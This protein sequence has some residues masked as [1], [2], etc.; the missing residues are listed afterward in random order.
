M[1]GTLGSADRAE[2]QCTPSSALHSYGVSFLRT[3]PVLLDTVSAEFTFPLPMNTLSLEARRT[4][5]LYFFL[6]FVT[7][8]QF[9]GMQGLTYTNE[10]FIY[11]FGSNSWSN[12][13]PTTKVGWLSVYS[14]CVL[15]HFFLSFFFFALTNSFPSLYSFFCWFVASFSKR[16]SL[17]SRWKFHFYVWRSWK[18]RHSHLLR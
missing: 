13:S 17:C 3:M 11:S 9:S 6:L 15:P 18:C 16:H 2:T 7:S 12:P 5:S 4:N 10:I 8:C 1:V 14:F